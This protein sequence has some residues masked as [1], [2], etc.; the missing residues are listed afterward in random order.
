[1]VKKI[2]FI[3]TIVEIDLRY[4]LINETSMVNNYFDKLGF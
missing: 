3:G 4:S 2:E 1:M